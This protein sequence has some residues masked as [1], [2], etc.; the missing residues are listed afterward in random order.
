[1]L[2]KPKFSIKHLIDTPLEVIGYYLVF[3]VL[4]S[5]AFS[6]VEGVPLVKAFYW[7][8]ITT[9]STGY[10]DVTPSG[11]PGYIL[12]FVTAHVGIFFFAPLIVGH[13]IMKLLPNQHEWTDE[14]QKKLFSML[15]KIN[16]GNNET[17]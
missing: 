10:G 2:I 8:F 1:M 4:A 17:K 13:F 12:T 15:E 5:L 16:G 6:W 7:A 3:L 9:T 11:I 14:E